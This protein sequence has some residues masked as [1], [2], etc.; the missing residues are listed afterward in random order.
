MKARYYSMS[1]IAEKTGTSR[2]VISAILNNNWR[3]KRISKKTFDRVSRAMDDI[4]YVPDRT[5]I[6]LRKE[7]RKSIGIVCHGPLHQ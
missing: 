1:E 4:G 2:Q 6:S 7:N 3:E 5:A